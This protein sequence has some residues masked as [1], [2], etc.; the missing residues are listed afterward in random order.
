MDVFSRI[1]VHLFKNGSIEAL[2]H[3]ESYRPQVKP[4]SR[5]QS[6]EQEFRERPSAS[7][8]EADKRVFQLTG[9]C[10]SDTC[11]GIAAS[12]MILALL[13][14]EFAYPLRFLAGDV[15][16]ADTQRLQRE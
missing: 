12:S 1:M 16:G 14:D 4:D 7:L 9:T 6:I 5:K 13:F 2:K 15:A 11:L 10:R 3:R 8:K